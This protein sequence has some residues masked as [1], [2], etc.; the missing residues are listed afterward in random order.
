MGKKR[1]E[2]LDFTDDFM[3]CKVLADNPEI[4]RELLELILGIKIKKVVVNKQEAI[5]ITADAKSVRFDVY[6]ED[7]ENTVFDVEMETTKKKNLPKRSRYY[8]GMIDLNIL[9]KGADYRDLKRSYVIFICLSDPFQDGLPV[10][11]FENRCKQKPE[12]S[13]GDEAVKVFINASGTAKGI[14]PQMAD[15]LRYL[16][17]GMGDSPLVKKIDAQVKKARAHEEWKVEYMTWQL[18]FH[19][20]WDDAREEGREEGKIKSLYQLVKKDIITLEVAAKEAELPVEDFVKKAL[21][22]QE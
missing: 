10:Y 11:T 22:L 1:Y 12:L 4:C 2:E 8:Q 20:I 21:E 14:S 18:K 17:T 13:L 15:F 5:S 3:F 7:E 19:D 6:A 9:Q 16:K